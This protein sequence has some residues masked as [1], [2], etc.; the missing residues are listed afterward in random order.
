M[1]VQK[2]LRGAAAKLAG[3]D[4]ESLL[5]LS[6]EMEHWARTCDLYGRLVSPTDVLRYAARIREALEVGS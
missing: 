2:V 5:R 3:I 4:V 6:S 1:S